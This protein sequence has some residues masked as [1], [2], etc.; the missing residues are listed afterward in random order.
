[1]V[2]TN[3][4]FLR[5]CCYRCVSWGKLYRCTNMVVGARC[6]V[7][8]CNDCLQLTDNTCLRDSDHMYLS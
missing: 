2:D 6:P 3:D 1:M 8:M 7:V 4:G 5:L